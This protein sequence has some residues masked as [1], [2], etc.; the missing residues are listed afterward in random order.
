MSASS[1]QRMPWGYRW[2]SSGLFVL[3]ATVTSVLTDMFLHQFLV[4]IL[5]SILEDR[6]NLDSALLQRVSVALLAQT[7]LISFLVTPIIGRLANYLHARTWL[8]LGLIGQLGGSV[9]IASTHSVITLFGGRAIQALAN[10]IVGILGAKSLSHVSSS[11]G[12]ERIQRILT[13]AVAA[14]SSGGPL[15]AGT[16]FEVS[17]YWTAW[18]SAF[19]ASLIG[20]ILQSM[21][22]LPTQEVSVETHVAEVQSHTD[23]ESNP[24]E[25]SPLLPASFKTIRTQLPADVKSAKRDLNLYFRLLT[26]RRYMGGILSSVCFAIVSGSF[27]TTLPLHVSEAFQ[28]GSQPT[29]MLF[30]VLH[31]PH[32]FL[33]AP[34]HWLKRRVGSHHTASVGF[35]GLAI[36]LWLA[37]T[38]GNERFSWTSPGGRGPVIY[39]S[40]IA[41]AGVFMSLLQG[42]GLMETA[43]AVQELAHE[44]PDTFDAEATLHAMVI[45]SL[46]LKLGL[47]L[48]PI[49]SGRLVDTWGYYDMNCVL[50]AM[51][52]GCAIVSAWNYE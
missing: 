51:C 26:S 49:I 44:Q 6:V 42:A 31:G 30:A 47:F 7:A 3:I 9:L 41:T 10:A 24:D 20:I 38:P 52:L 17:N 50:A 21:M 29:G 43:R 37:G 36:L 12:H 33:S 39:A 25:N 28:W 16:L 48:G 27:D 13:L 45:S 8:L 22:L 2:R 46:S 5:P 1:P 14:G 15:V 18:K 11:D 4:S 23:T 40:A 35:F 34:V 32:V 19:A